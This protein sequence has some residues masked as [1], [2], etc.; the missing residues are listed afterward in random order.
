M[1][2]LNNILVPVD[3]SDPSKAAVRYGLALAR[4]FKARLTLAHVVPFFPFVHYSFPPEPFNIE[5]TGLDG[6]TAQ[7]NSLI[8]S[9]HLEGVSFETIARTG[10]IQLELSAII[11]ERNIDM[12]IMGTHGR[13]AVERFMLGSVTE[14]MLRR[15]RVPVL[16][17]S[18]LDP[19]H[20][21]HFHEPIPLRR[22]IY[23]T[24]LLDEST[25]R[26]R[27]VAELARGAGA[28]LS[29]VHVVEPPVPSYMSAEM[30]SLP[31]IDRNAIRR[32]AYEQL[33]KL[34][35]PERDGTLPILLVLREGIPYREIIGYADDSKA[36]LIVLNLQ[37][38]GR[39]ERVVLGSTAERVIR[40]A[41]VPVLG[42]PGLGNYASHC[43]V[44]STVTLAT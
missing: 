4:L 5:E 35:A 26:F 30:V 42:L 28:T 43:P 15:V 12:V 13:R 18:H 39:L 31:P 38:L 8:P 6:A 11:R 29:V 14:R 34:V 41:T 33:L 27:F 20:T 36:D 24:S 37:E 7:M 44:P 10:D 3:F 17:V 32:F 19:A 1:M 25:D 22:I 16:T 23:A 2:R 9:E 40:A 21:V